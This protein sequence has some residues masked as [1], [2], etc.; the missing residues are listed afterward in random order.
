MAKKLFQKIVGVTHCN[1]RG[2]SSQYT[3][4]YIGRRQLE[5]GCLVVCHTCR[6]RQ[7]GTIVDLDPPIKKAME[8]G[9]KPCSDARHKDLATAGWT[10]TKSISGVNY[11]EPP[12]VEEEYDYY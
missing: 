4:L 5:P 12:E 2:E 9:L 8:Y 1:G 11:W 6:G 10:W 3:F 7:I